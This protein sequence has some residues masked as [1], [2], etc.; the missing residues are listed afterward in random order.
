M[1]GAHFINRT[2]VRETYT[3]TMTETKAK[4]MGGHTRTRARTRTIPIVLP[5]RMTGQMREPFG[6]AQFFQYLPIVGEKTAM[7]FLT[8]S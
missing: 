3:L 7:K 8:E 1:Q 5:P 2:Q 4:T 6:Q